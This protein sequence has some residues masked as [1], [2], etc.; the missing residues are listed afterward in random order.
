LNIPDFTRFAK[1]QRDQLIGQ[2]LG[3]PIPMAI[4]AFIAVAVA[5]A[6][7]VI[8]G[9]ALWDPVA[10]TERMGGF[11]V[12]IALIALVIATLTTNLAANMV[13][14]ANGFANLSPGKISFRMGGYITAGLGIAIM[15]WKLLA[16]TGAYIF[17]WLIGYSAL[18]GPLAGIMLADYLLLRKT[19]LS[20]DDLFKNNGIYSYANGWNPMAWIAFIVAVLPNLPGFLSAAGFVESV[21]VIFS[22]IYNYSWFVGAGIGIVVYLGLMKMYRPAT[23]NWSSASSYN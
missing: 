1:S 20:L 22:T 11:A 10:I 13:A 7:V 17:T 9:E 2:A 3:L 6:T 18:L 15:P 8:Y 14:P 16:T 5:S 21:P 19:E 4:L 12:V 23:A